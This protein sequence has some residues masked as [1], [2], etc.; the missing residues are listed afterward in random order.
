MKTFHH[1]LRAVTIVIGICVLLGCQTN[2]TSPSATSAAAADPNAGRLTIFRAPNL[3]EMLVV[4]ID[5]GK[6]NVVRTGDTFTTSLSPG[7]HVI[8]ATLQPNQLHLAPTKV[9]LTVAKGGNYAF[10]AMWEGERLILKP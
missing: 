3:A 8:S 5:A 6:P 7:Q 4:T 1:C 2:S 10:T 9:N